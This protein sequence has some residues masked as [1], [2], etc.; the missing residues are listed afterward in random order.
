MAATVTRIHT[1]APRTLRGSAE[2]FLDSIGPGNTRRAYGIAVVKTVDQLDGRSPDGLHLD[3]VH[4]KLLGEPGHR[5]RRRRRPPRH[6]PQPRQR[7]QRDR[8]P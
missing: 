2:A 4:P 6:E 5:H 8:R 7:A 1:A 3:R